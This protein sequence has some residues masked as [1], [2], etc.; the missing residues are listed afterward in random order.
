MLISSLI[1]DQHPDEIFF[2]NQEY[3][4]IMKVIVGFE[5]TINVIPGIKK[6]KSVAILLQRT[7]REEFFGC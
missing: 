5:I 3:T 2:Q 6:H 1:F 7:R 4:S